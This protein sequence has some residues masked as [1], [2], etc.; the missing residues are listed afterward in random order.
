MPMR[1]RPAIE[2]DALRREGLIRLQARLAEAR[3]LKMEIA[4]LAHKTKRTGIRTDTEAEVISLLAFRLHKA[5]YM[6]SL[7]K[8]ALIGL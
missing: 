2:R 8:Q 7:I 5:T 4:R 3:Q 6:V 1:R